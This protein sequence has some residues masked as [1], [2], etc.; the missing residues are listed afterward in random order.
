MGRKADDIKKVLEQRSLERKLDSLDDVEN[1]EVEELEQEMLGEMDE[2][3]AESDEDYEII[4]DFDLLLERTV[5][6]GYEAY[7]ADQ[8]AD[9]NPYILYESDDEDIKNLYVE[10]WNQGWHSAHVETCMAGVVVAAHRF[11]NASSP[12]EA[13][14]KFAQLQESLGILGEVSDLDYLNEA[15]DE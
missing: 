3:I 13:D 2:E 4:E 5:N 12:E 8:E 9:A 11:V 10:A 7:F 15:W 1:G 6:E 14:A